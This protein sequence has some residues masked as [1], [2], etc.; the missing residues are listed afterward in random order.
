MSVIKEIGNNFLV[1]SGRSERS[2]IISVDDTSELHGASPFVHINER[3]D[4]IVRYIDLIE[5]I[6]RGKCAP[7]FFVMFAFSR[8]K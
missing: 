6:I 2:E 4:L 3:I 8:N 5:P 7:Y 1:T